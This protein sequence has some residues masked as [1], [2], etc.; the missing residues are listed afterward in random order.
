MRL[1]A[2]KARTA[3]AA[4]MN[5]RAAACFKKGLRRIADQPLVLKG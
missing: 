3:D 4:T 2:R 1:K 5:R